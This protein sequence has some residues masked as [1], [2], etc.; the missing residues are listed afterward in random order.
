MNCYSMQLYTKMQEE[1][2]E[3]EVDCKNEILMVEGCFNIAVFY[4]N[5]IKKYAESYFFKHENEEITFFKTIKP[6]F[7]AAIEYYTLYY[8]AILFKPCNEEKELT[9]YWI[10][11]L[12]RVE[13]FYNRHKEFYCY[14][15][16]GQTCRDKLYFL[17]N[18]N[19]VQALHSTQFNSRATDAHDAIAARI[20]S[21]QKYRSYVETQLHQ[22]LQTAAQ[23]SPAP[24]IVAAV[25]TAAP[26]HILNKQTI[27]T[28]N[29]FYFIK[30]TATV[31]TN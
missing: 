1:L 31:T 6:L 16:S 13:I 7:I 17:K 10:Q 28:S 3:L 30:F 8:Q 4:W 9:A 11:Q 21:Y 26:C 23:Q 24:S 18:G 14:Y 25:P 22:L 27:V 29:N 12:K 20:L 5:K 2:N 19:T 15:T